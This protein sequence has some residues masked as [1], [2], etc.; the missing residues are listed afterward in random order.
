VDVTPA[1]AEVSLDG[2]RLAGS[3][4]AISLPKDNLEHELHVEAEGYEPHTRKL[5]L[6]ADLELSLELKALPAQAGKPVPSRR[7]PPVRPAPP[8]PTPAPP[9]RT[10]PE[11]PKP[12]GPDCSTPYFIGADGLKHYRRECL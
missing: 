2:Q 12:S 1:D 10:E 11:R 3:P 6:A 7:R 8:R 9:E 5:R 4:P